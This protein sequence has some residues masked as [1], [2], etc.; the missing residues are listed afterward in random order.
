M[1]FIQIHPF[2]G[3]VAKALFVPYKVGVLDHTSVVY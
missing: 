3:I 2:V 1:F